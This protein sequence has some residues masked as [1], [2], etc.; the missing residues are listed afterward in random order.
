[1]ERYQWFAFGEDML[2]SR[3][4]KN[5]FQP[6]DIP[7]SKPPP[8]S[9]S[10][11]FLRVGILVAL[12]VL[13]IGGPIYYYIDQQGIS[14]LTKTDNSIHIEKGKEVIAVHQLVADGNLVRA[15]EVIQTLYKLH[16]DD[17]EYVSTGA[18]VYFK[19]ENYRQAMK[20]SETAVKLDPGRAR[21]HAILGASRL[22]FKQYK[23]ALETSLKAIQLDPDQ[24]LAYLTVGEIYL[25][26]NDAERALPALKHAGR[27]DS[28]NARVWTRLSSAFIKLEKWD[29][30]LLSAERA[31][32]LAKDTPGVHFNLAMIYYKKQQGLK[33]VEHM[34]KAEDLYQQ[35]GQLEWAGK[36]RQ[37]KE[38]IIR[39]FKLRPED[40]TP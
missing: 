18:W 22:F 24:S 2:G 35:I 21:D 5:R 33:S 37:N 25:K 8:E 16:P 6:E 15:L 17:A 4:D 34:Q 26:E 20:L 7:S 40:I 38:L 29:K 14:L 13:L 1:M 32:E 36:A 39:H 9:T 3:S 23:P 31:L 10:A 30:A 12:A 28:D 27:L 19:M 11:K